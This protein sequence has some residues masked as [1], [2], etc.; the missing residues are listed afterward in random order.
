MLKPLSFQ[1]SA[2]TF[3][4]LALGFRLLAL[5]FKLSPFPLTS[6]PPL[7]GQ[8]KTEPIRCQSMGVSTMP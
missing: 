1:L 6:L 7:H 2:F 8:P 5:S 3:Q 4:L